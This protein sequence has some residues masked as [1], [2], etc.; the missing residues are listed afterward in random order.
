MCYTEEEIERYLEIL[1][2]YNNT[3]SEGGK[4]QKLDVGIVKAIV[5]LLNQVIIFVILVEQLMAMFL[6]ILT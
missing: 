3:Q 5:S 2:S 6:V 4:I 1:R